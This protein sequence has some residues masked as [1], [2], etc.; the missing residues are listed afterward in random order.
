ME[1]QFERINS[2]HFKPNDDPI[3]YIVITHLY[4]EHGLNYLIY[5]ECKNF[6]RLL[7]NTFATKLDLCYEMKLISD[8][9]F[10][11]IRTL[12]SLRNKMV[13]NL[14]I[15]FENIRLSMY[16]TQNEPMLDLSEF[17]VLDDQKEALTLMILN[18]GMK[19]ITPLNTL[20]AVEYLD[21]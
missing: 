4:V 19:T 10:N 1:Y 3:G 13:H 15:D 14:D 8:F 9:L 7:K 2:W 5:R 20:I 17:M 18:L 6:K 16:S 12:N 21:R 11:N